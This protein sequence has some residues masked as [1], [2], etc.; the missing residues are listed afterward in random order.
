MAIQKTVTTKF[1][2]DVQDAYIR[3]ERLSGGKLNMSATFAIYASKAAAENGAR[4]L[5]TF[6]FAFMPNLSG[7]NFISQAY[8]EL[9][10]QD[11]F[12][13]ARDV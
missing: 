9:K 4:E 12:S 11:G 7:A 10:K 1:G 13:E 6:E 2:L 5:E 8:I 3:V